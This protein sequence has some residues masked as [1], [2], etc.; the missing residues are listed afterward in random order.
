MSDEQARDEQG[1]FA[2]GGGSGG[3]SKTIKNA[4]S[5]AARAS[6]AAKAATEKASSTGAES[7]HH[8]ASEAHANAADAH[9]DLHDF[10]TAV[11]NHDAAMQ[12][13]D[14]VDS[15]T[16]QHMVHNREVSRL[17]SANPRSNGKSPMEN[18]ANA[19]G[20]QLR[21]AHEGKV[22]AEKHEAKVARLKKWAKKKSR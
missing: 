21:N 5:K 19:V 13:L 12:A 20:T 1:R 2:S 16:E 11:G 9:F 18:L 15:H 6:E 17:R 14:K 3:G 22:R 10:H 7:D 4:E 8:A